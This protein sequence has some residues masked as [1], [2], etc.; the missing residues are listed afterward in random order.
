MRHLEFN[1]VTIHG[2]ETKD[3]DA[4]VYVSLPL[5]F[6]FNGGRPLSEY[7]QHIKESLDM[8]ISTIFE[9]I[10]FIGESMRNDDVKA[11]N[12]AEYLTLLGRIGAAFQPLQD[13]MKSAFE[14]FTKAEPK[15]TVLDLSNH[16]TKEGECLDLAKHLSAVMLDKNTPT[17]VYNA[18]A[19]ELT[20][21]NIQPEV[22]YSPEHIVSILKEQT[23]CD[24]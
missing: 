18:L 22:Y 1:G 24:E 17:A 23:E 12:A 20:K 3:G 15:E 9:L 10:E 16:S 4:L 8:D 14:R 2:G 19:D 21:Q 5:F 6:R 13:D 11:M 7:E